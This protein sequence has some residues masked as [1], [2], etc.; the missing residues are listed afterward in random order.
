MR[1]TAFDLP[2]ALRL[3]EELIRVTAFP[4]SPREIC[5]QGL[6]LVARALGSPTAMTLM[7]EPDGSCSPACTVGDG[8][9]TGMAE[10]AAAILESGSPVL[11]EPPGQ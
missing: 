11:A 5:H 1:K 8:P 9:W 2:A 3:L 7:R 10:A 6:S 4:A